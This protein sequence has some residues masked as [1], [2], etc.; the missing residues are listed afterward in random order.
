[1]RKP[2]VRSGFKKPEQVR[3]TVDSFWPI[4]DAAYVGN[5]PVIMSY[6]S[7]RGRKSAFLYSPHGV[8]NTYIRPGANLVHIIK[9]A[10]QRNL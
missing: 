10:S 6:G 5:L 9:K 4:L 7:L 3:Y 8:W 1:M 2:H